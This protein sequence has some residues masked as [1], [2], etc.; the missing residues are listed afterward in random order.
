[1]NIGVDAYHYF[2][3]NQ[4]MLHKLLPFVKNGGFMAI[5]VPGFTQDV[6][7]GQLPK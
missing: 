7:F 4:S 1:M 6:P 5:A 3:S 2:G